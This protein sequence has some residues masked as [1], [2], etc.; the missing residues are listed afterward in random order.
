MQSQVPEPLCS[1]EEETS[2]NSSEPCL[3][4]CHFRADFSE[5]HHPAKK[6]LFNANPVPGRIPPCPDLPGSH[7]GTGCFSQE[8]C[9][10]SRCQHRPK[11]RRI[12]K[13]PVMGMQMEQEQILK[14]PYLCLPLPCLVQNSQKY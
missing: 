8:R 1:S 11:H 12:S 2:V 5:K 9:I 4:I 10:N 6:S 13:L 3:Q 7:F 14:Q